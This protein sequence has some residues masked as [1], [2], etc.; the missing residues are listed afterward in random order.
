MTRTDALA[1]LERELGVLL[2]RVRRALGARAA[3]IHPDLQSVAYLMLAYVVEEGPQRSSAI[4]ER[5]DID[6]GA[7]SRQVQHLV[8]LGLFERKPDP[9]DG[10]ASSLRVTARGRKR[11]DEVNVLR[12]EWLDDR[13]G[14]WE[15]SE[16][17]QFA[18]MLGRY[19]ESLEAGELIES[20][21]PDRGVRR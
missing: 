10:R 20:P 8:E 21:Q 19:N 14:G 2:R 4:A 17:Q 15:D 16:L 9:A 12:R 13:L 3:M 5:F 1:G 18:D 6:K 7:V 11:Y